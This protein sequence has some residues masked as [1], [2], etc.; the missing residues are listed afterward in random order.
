MDND[1]IMAEESLKAQL[2][3]WVNCCRK[4][5]DKATKS[6]KVIERI[7]SD[8][9]AFVQERCAVSEMLANEGENEEYYA[10]RFDAYCNVGGF[11]NELKKEIL[12]EA[13]SDEKL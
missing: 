13:Q 1:N 9:M 3:G 11:V 6:E 4:W 10:G 7:C 2:N 5:Q 8:I 12:K